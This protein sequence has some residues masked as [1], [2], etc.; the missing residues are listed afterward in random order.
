MPDTVENQPGVTDQ[1]PILQVAGAISGPPTGQGIGSIVDP[2]TEAGW[3]RD[4]LAVRGGGATGGAVEVAFRF[5]VKAE[6]RHSGK[7]FVE[8]EPDIRAEWSSAPNRQPWD[9][10]REAIWA[11]F[12]RARDQRV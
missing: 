2:V 5:G 3:V 10:L 6:G 9:D 4:Y 8:A 1:L 12:D 11:G 7:S